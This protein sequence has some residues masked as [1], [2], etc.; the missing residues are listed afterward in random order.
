MT[1][2]MQDL[3]QAI[4]LSDNQFTASYIEDSR[5]LL[6]QNMPHDSDVFEVSPGA[7]IFVRVVL[8]DPSPTSAAA[9]STTTL[10]AKK[11]EAMHD[12][13]HKPFE[14]VPVLDRKRKRGSLMDEEISVFT[15]MTK[16]VKEVTTAIRE[17]K[18]LDVHPGLHPQGA[19]AQELTAQALLLELAAGY[20]VHDSEWTNGMLCSSER[21]LGFIA[22]VKDCSEQVA[23]VLNSSH[24]EFKTRRT[25]EEAYAHYVRKHIDGV[26][27][28]EVDNIV[29]GKVAPCLAM[30]N[31]IIVVQF[32]AFALLWY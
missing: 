9:A 13:P 10:K 26:I 8:I 12:G 22:R 27:E 1:T 2:Q 29:V 6:D 25:A 16:A 28:V 4:V 32:I 21:Y 14:L 3:S 19:L 23:S 5:P 11:D 31:F 30:K 20:H 18:T 24:T 15:S 7:S 17:S